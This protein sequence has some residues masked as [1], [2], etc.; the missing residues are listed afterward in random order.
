MHPV[1]TL[2][3]DTYTHAV[4]YMALEFHVDAPPPTTQGPCWTFKNPFVY[5]DEGSVF[6]KPVT[7]R[8][9]R[10]VNHV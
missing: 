2:H 3:V 6:P 4:Q 5:L 7:T 1:Y 9:S 8:G 10:C